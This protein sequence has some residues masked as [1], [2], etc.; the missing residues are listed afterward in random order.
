MSFLVYFGLCD[1]KSIS[2]ETRDC[3]P[4]FFFALHLF[5][6]FFFIYLLWVCV[7]LCLWDWS[8]EY[9]TLIGLDFLSNL[10]ICVFWPGHFAL[11]HLRLILLWVSLFCH[12]DTSWLFYPLVDPVSSWCQ[13]SLP[14]GTFLQWLVLVVSSVALVRQAWWCWNLSAIACLLRIF[15]PFTYEA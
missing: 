6:K 8:P 4:W 15:V 3:S 12:F 5:G 13:W 9:S 7:C 10:P 14:F 2:L 1:V 11:L